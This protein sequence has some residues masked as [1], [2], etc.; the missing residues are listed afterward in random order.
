M[1][2]TFCPSACFRVHLMVVDLDRTHQLRQA[3]SIPSVNGPDFGFWHIPS[4]RGHS[5]IATVSSLV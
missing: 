5:N 4:H 3:G 1:D 2:R